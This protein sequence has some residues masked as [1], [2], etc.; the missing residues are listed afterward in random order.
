[1]RKFEVGK[2][3]DAYQKEYGNI[4]IL[5]RTEK[6][7]WVRNGDGNDWYMRV[8]RDGSGNEYAVDSVVDKKWRDAFT[9]Q[10]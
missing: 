3:Y 8:K 1:M 2:T 9:Y 6:T 7:I 5:R 10:A 4:T